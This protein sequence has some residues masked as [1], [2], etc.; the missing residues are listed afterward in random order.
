MKLEL[1]V[2]KVSVCM[3]SSYLLPL[4]PHTV[5]GYMLSL[6]LSTA[7]LNTL[8]PPLAKGGYGLI[9]TLP[10]CGGGEHILPANNTESAIYC[11]IMFGTC[12][13]TFRKVSSNWLPS[14]YKWSPYDSWGP[15]MFTFMYLSHY[16]I[17]QPWISNLC[18]A[19]L[20]KGGHSPPL[21]DFHSPLLDFKN[22]TTNSVKKC[23]GEHAPRLS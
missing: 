8:T 7:P 14:L 13:R 2:C 6:W 18:Q 19:S 11:L 12:N 5:P 4:P 21:I 9:H 22:C 1:R 23:L 17:T 15:K 20:K 16:Y 3:C 10:V